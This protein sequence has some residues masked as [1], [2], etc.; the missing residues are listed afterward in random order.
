MCDGQLHIQLREH[1]W[2]SLHCI[3]QS[4][5]ADTKQDTA[6]MEQIPEPNRALY[7]FVCDALRQLHKYSERVPHPVP[8]PSPFAPLERRL[9][10]PKASHVPASEDSI[11]SSKGKHSA[12][13]PQQLSNR[14]SGILCP[15][16]ARFISHSPAWEID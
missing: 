13:H 7:L 10:G 3:Q 11:S 2:L 6:D 4:D 14:K 9:D 15:Q 12:T 16:G 8:A 5:T 1:R